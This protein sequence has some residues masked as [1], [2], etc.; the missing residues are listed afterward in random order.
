[1]NN[2]VTAIFKAES[3]PKLDFSEGMPAEFTTLVVVPTLLMKEKQVRELFDDLEVRFLANQDPNI[4]FGC[5]PIFP[6]RS[7]DRGRTT[8]IPWSTLLFSLIDE[9]NERYASRASG[10]FLPASSPSHL[11]SPPG[12]VDGMGAQTRQAPRPEQ[13]SHGEFDPFPVKA[14][15]LECAHARAIRH[16][17]RFRYAASAGH[18]AAPDRRH[19]ASAQS[20]HH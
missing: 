5:S 20:R 11:Q 14:G 19:G 13:V 7:P 2:T 12:R 18:G 17:A 10:I 15:N 16:H 8:P 3:L 6:I 1:M 9:L 4:H